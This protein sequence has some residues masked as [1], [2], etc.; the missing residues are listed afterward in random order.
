MIP[1]NWKFLSNIWVLL[2]LTVILGISLRLFWAS[3]DPPATPRWDFAGHKSSAI[4]LSKGK[5]DDYL[6]YKGPGIAPFNAL[7]I[8]IT[9]GKDYEHMLIF[10]VFFLFPLTSFFFLLLLRELIGRMSRIAVIGPFLLSILPEY[11][12]IAHLY[13]AENVVLF[14]IIIT[15][16]GFFLAHRKKTIFYVILSGFVFGVGLYIKAL[17]LA[18]APFLALSFF[19]KLDKTFPFIKFK[20]GKNNIQFWHSAIFTASVI[21]T[22][23]PWWMYTY[24][25]MGRPIISMASYGSMVFYC[26]NQPFGDKAWTSASRRRAEMVPEFIEQPIQQTDFS[27][28]VDYSFA[29]LW[30]HPGSILEDLPFNIKSEFGYSGQMGYATYFDTETRRPPPWQERVDKVVFFIIL[31][32]GIL[33]F[34]SNNRNSIRFFESMLRL[35]FIYVMLFLP[36]FVFQGEER[37]RM[38]GMPLII[39]FATMYFYSV[40]TEKHPIRPMMMGI[41]NFAR[42]LFSI[43]KQIVLLPIQYGK[44]TT[45]SIVAIVAVIIIIIFSRD[46]IYLDINN[47]VE[48][49]V[50]VIED[51][52]LANPNPVIGL[53]IGENPSENYYESHFKFDAEPG[54][55]KMSA[56]YSA[57]IP[58]PLDVI[59]N[60]TLLTKYLFH[61]GFA[62]TPNK[63]ARWR[64]IAEIELK[65]G[66]NILSLR[67]SHHFDFPI[68]HKNIT[69]MYWGSWLAKLK[70]VKKKDAEISFIND[71]GLKI[72]LDSLE[73]RK[74]IY[75]WSKLYPLETPLEK[76]KIY[77]LYF[78]GLIKHSKKCM[79]KFT[80]LHYDSVGKQINKYFS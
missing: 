42:H 35:I 73:K 54:T 53:S 51:G 71:H 66:E 48:S 15:L 59:I 55:Y 74:N 4:N 18:I 65:A 21:I 25:Q 41:S 63:F 1:N 75:F 46:A 7:G 43:I 50:T 67:E 47:L 76:G 62:G 3:P 58:N 8:L 9:G 31:K 20:F 45:I 29:Y 56:L 39:S 30:H 19:I 72:E 16:W 52:A 38:P 23:L 57:E 34:L 5:I 36:I 24:T 2:L 28:L 60:N 64:D 10:N 49:K 14:G 69:Q 78:P 44:T 26:N 17:F 77:T 40:Y 13:A 70:T 79:I 80:V 12:Y 32:L 6:L 37:H 22:V 27:P 68:I 33:G 61:E 11:I